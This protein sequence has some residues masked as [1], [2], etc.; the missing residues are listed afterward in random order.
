MTHEAPNV[1]VL[2]DGHAAG[3]ARGTDVDEEGH[4]T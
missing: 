4:G 3:A 2:I 1:R